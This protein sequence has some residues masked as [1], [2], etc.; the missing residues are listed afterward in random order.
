MKKLLQ[1]L[2]LLVSVNFLMAQSVTW[3]ADPMHTKLTFR[4]TH[5]GISSVLG[6]FQKFDLTVVSSKADFSDAV[7]TLSADVA[8]IDTGVKMR[9]DDLRGAKYFDVAKYPVMTFKSTSIRNTTGMKDRFKI[10]GELTMHGVSKTVSVEVWFRGMVVDPK[11]KKSRVGFEVTGVV[12]RS[13]FNVG[14]ADSFGVGTDV[15]IVA[16]GEFVGE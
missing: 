13:D 14:P 6:S 16:D 11:S 8:S 9:D 3:K 7:F 10:S 4:V 1:V 12:D 5:M 2:V 15:M